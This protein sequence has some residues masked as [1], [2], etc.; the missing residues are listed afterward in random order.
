M[1]G[2]INPS[3]VSFNI[4]ALWSNKILK[5]QLMLFASLLALAVFNTPATADLD[6]VDRAAMHRLI[7]QYITDNPE[8]LRD[9]LM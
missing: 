4:Q 2:K 7:K 5:I 8:V 1:L 9:A 3:I 6:K